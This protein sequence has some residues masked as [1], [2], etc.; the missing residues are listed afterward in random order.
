MN[1]V[2][3]ILAK[4]KTDPSYLEL[5]NLDDKYE[6]KNILSYILFEHPED[7]L[8]HIQFFQ[9]S[10]SDE[11]A[12]K[13]VTEN[14]VFVEKEKIQTGLSLI[15]EH[16]PSLNKMHD[17]ILHKIVQHLNNQTTAP[18]LI[19][20]ILEMKKHA[21]LNSFH[22]PMLITNL[23]SSIPLIEKGINFSQQ[24]FMGSQWSYIHE[25]IFQ[26]NATCLDKK[27][28]YF[29]NLYYLAR[30]HNVSNNSLLNKIISS[31][32]NLP[33]YHTIDFSTFVIHLIKNTTELSTSIKNKTIDESK[34]ALW[35]FFMKH[36][37]KDFKQI[38]DYLYVSSQNIL[39]ISN[40]NIQ[41]AVKHGLIDHLRE[42]HPNFLK[43]MFVTLYQANKI[44]AI[45]DEKYNLSTYDKRSFQKELEI[46]AEKFTLVTKN[47]EKSRIKLL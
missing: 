4:A 3:N 1:T 31:D 28:S 7:F 46:I 44:H 9:K 13:I 47:T 5:I 41:T 12:K 32:K 36:K 43:H 10:I 8:Q 2:Q 37:P 23:I 16:F 33:N 39:H 15:L 21:P 25:G 38:P 17:D 34:G 40:Q 14:L 27:N 11:K 35:A 18:I 45:T 22:K 29:T 20:K 24:D 30:K 19:N 6:E 26:E 42:N